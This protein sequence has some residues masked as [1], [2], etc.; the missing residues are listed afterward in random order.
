VFP[1]RY[2]LNSYILSRRNI[3]LNI[4][5]HSR[6]PIKPQR[7][8]KA[9]PRGDSLL[10]NGNLY[11]SQYALNSGLKAPRAVRSWVPWD[12]EPRITVLTKTSF[13]LAFFKG[14]T[15]LCQL[16]KLQEIK[17]SCTVNYK[18]W[19]EINSGYREFV[20]AEKR[21]I[22]TP[23]IPSYATLHGSNL[24]YSGDRLLLFSLKFSVA[25]LNISR[26]AAVP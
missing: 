24:T 14:L 19:E 12:S 17:R 13:D 25:F 18:D 5:G 3:V 4:W 16:Q 20:C 11:A 6:E 2:E 10:G 8:G 23:N 26:T 22:M 7:N 21:V 9:S 15:I 1:V